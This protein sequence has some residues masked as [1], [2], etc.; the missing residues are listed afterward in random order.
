MMSALLTRPG[1][2]D[3]DIKKAV[4]ALGMADADVAEAVDDA[5]AVEDAIGG[6]QVV[7]R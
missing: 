6:D 7:D 4:L 3:A 5:L 2:S 1:A